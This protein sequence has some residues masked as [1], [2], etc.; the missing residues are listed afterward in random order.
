[1]SFT[2]SPP[3]GPRT[4]FTT[5]RHGRYS[6]PEKKVVGN[7]WVKAKNTLLHM[8]KLNTIIQFGEILMTVVLIL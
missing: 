8:E 3:A 7:K 5:C 1:M 4:N 6:T 2:A